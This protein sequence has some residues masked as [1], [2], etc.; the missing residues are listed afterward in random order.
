MYTLVSAAV[1]ACDLA[2]HPTGAAVADV[3]DRLLALDSLAALD[4]DPTSRQACTPAAAE[5][6]ERVLVAVSGAPRM[7]RLMDGV[8]ATLRD[9]LPDAQTSRTVLTAL[10]ETPLGGLEDLH[11]LLRLELSGTPAQRQVAEDAVTAAWAGREADLHD[12][13]ALQGPWR[14]AQAP[15]PPALPASTYQGE[16]T[17]LLEAIGRR[18]PEQWQRVADAHGAHRG[19]FRWSTAMHASCAAAFDAGIT[20]DVARAQLCAA[21]ALRLSRASTGHESHALAMAT[22]AAVQA[23]CTGHLLDTTVLREAWVAGFAAE[24]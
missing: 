21:R 14:D 3:L 4:G 23:T 17:A 20:R 12:L 16:L 10:S 7:S 5:V 15:V 19:T 6:R 13:H 18:S 11:R 22:T 9:G 1:L 2:R 24:A 8:T